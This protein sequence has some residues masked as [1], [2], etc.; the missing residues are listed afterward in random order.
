MYGQARN[1]G[2]TSNLTEEPFYPLTSLFARPSGKEPPR[3]D[4]PWYDAGGT[5]YDEVYLDH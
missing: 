5:A 2:C 3:A 4:V 1:I